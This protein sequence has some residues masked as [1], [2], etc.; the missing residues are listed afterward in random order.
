MTC[1]CKFMPA[2]KVR[3]LTLLLQLE[4]ARTLSDELIHTSIHI[5]DGFN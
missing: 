3:A 1:A 2:I 4:I 5:Q